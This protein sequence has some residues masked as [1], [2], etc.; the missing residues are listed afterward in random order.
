MK[1]LPGLLLFRAQVAFALLAAS[2]GG[3]TLV[4]RDWI[5]AILRIDP[6]HGAGDVEAV[7]AILCFVATTVLSIQAARGWRK[8]RAAAQA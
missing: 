3:L 4:R 5:E 2:L 8:V 6:D 7:L 1:R